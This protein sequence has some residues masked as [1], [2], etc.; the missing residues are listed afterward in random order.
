MKLLLDAEG[1]VVVRNGK[2]VYV[3]DAGKEIEFD[4]AGT[5]A[6][7][8]GLRTELG[9]MTK[10]RDGLQTV[11]EAFKG[12]D[13][14]AAR[15]ALDTVKNLDDKK[16]IDAGEVEKVRNETKA[17]LEAQFEP[18][19]REN[20]SL[21]IQFFN[22]KVGGAFARSKFI[23]EKLAIPADFA[24]ARFGQ[25]VKLDK[26]GNI[27]VHH[28]SG[29]PVYSRA[30]PGKIAEFDEAM[31]IVVDSYP[32]KARILKGSG[33]T[34]SGTQNGSGGGG[35]DKQT[36]TRSAF[37]KLNPVDQAAHAA[38]AAKGEVKIVEG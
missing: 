6:T 27:V 14:A 3:T 29:E 18:V 33:A 15:K 5:T 35:G 36:M 13:P 12:L 9:D 7:I 23:G 8:Q 16:L 34:G 1:K 37:Q 32:D 30:N 19:K 10:A 24:Q 17:A 38:K 25:Q 21:K 26:D 11:A 31:E 2:P 20:E 22:E 4:A 28:T